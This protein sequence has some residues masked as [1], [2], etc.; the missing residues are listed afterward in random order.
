MAKKRTSTTQSGKVKKRNIQST[1]N[2]DINRAEEQEG[3]PDYGGMPDR[4]LKK[5]LGCG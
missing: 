2:T 4:N 1:K 5:N 3:R